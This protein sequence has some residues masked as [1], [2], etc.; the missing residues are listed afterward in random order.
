MQSSTLLDTSF[1]IR[2]LNKEDKLHSQ[3]KSYFKYFLDKE[4]ELYVSTIAI[5]EYCVRGRA[6]DLPLKN[7]RILPFNMHHAIEAGKFANS[8]FAKRNLLDI[9]RAVI[10]ND[11]K[12]FAQASVESRINFY[13]TSDTKSKTVVD[14]LK[15]EHT[16]DFEFIDI[17][18][19]YNERFGV[20]DL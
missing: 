16:V 7:L 6:T 12:L 15:E 20:L 17:N 19:P 1:F 18:I 11:T 9:P 10:P 2:L 14:L 4:F 8:L 13:T 5:A 3:A